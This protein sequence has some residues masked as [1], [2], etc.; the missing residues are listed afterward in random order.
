M[1][2]NHINSNRNLKKTLCRN[3]I[4]NGYCGYGTKCMYA[5]SLDEQKMD[6]NHKKG[7][8]ILNLPNLHNFNLQSDIVLYKSLLHLTRVCGDCIAGKCEGGYNCKYG[9]C[10]EKF[11]ICLKDLKYGTCD[12]NKCGYIHLTSRGL[13]PYYYRNSYNS[14]DVIQG[15]LLTKEYFGTSSDCDEDVKNNENIDFNEEN[16]DDDDKR[17]NNNMEQTDVVLL[18]IQDECNLSIF[19]K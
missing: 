5:H 9:A 15:T 10:S 19:E 14:Y 16:S 11:Q 2:S 12:S 4:K 6:F 17:E 3:I 18:S 13:K 1:I 7:Y 8:D